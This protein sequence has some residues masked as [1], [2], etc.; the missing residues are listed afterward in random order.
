MWRRSQVPFLEDGEFGLSFSHANRT[1][2]AEVAKRVEDVALFYGCS[3][4][5]IRIER[6]LEAFLP[7]F[8]PETLASICTVFV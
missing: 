8:G 5:T 2:E 4:S 3:L 6:E 1:L 7:V